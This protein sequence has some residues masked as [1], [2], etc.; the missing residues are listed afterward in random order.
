MKLLCNVVCGICI[1]I[2][3]LLV[4][5]APGDPFV[6]FAACCFVLAA[7]LLDFHATRMGRA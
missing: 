5:V 6:E 1:S 3:L 7:A 2:A 4:M